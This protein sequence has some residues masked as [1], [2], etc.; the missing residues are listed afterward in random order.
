M[1]K[2]VVLSSVLPSFIFQQRIDAGEIINPSHQLYF[3]RL[4]LSLSKLTPIQIICLTPIRKM[5]NIVWNQELIHRDN[6]QVYLQFAHPNY[7]F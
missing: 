4:I 3:S 6:Q 1:N 5:K 7:R 2:Y